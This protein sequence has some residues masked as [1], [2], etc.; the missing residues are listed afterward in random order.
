M[1]M[2]ST[3]KSLHETEDL[4]I[5]SILETTPESLKVR[6]V[7]EVGKKQRDYFN[8][9]GLKFL[10]INLNSSLARV[11]YNFAMNNEGNLYLDGKYIVCEIDLIHHIK[12]YRQG[13][14]P[15]ELIVQLHEIGEDSRKLLKVAKVVGFS[16]DDI[17][18]SDDI[19]EGI[20]DNKIIPADDYRIGDK[21]I[22]H[23]A[24]FNEIIVP[25]G[26]FNKTTM[27]N[28]LKGHTNRSRIDAHTHKEHVDEILAKEGYGPVTGT[29]IVLNGYEALTLDPKVLGVKHSEARFLSYT[30]ENYLHLEFH[31]DNE[32][33]ITE[34]GIKLIKPLFL[35]ST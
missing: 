12:S 25:N 35:E 21:G 22:L 30:H 7:A 4:T 18:T 20:Y 34:I 11:G 10:R 16:P 28:I 23:L 19:I 24:L 27:E 31:G 3:R 33:P 6:L 17:L 8:S 26:T 1:E 29:A 5:E 32:D 13:F 2:S 14:D 9:L 15:L